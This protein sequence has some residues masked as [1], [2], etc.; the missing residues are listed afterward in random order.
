M[1]KWVLIALGLVAVVVV[2]VATRFFVNTP[3]QIE[4]AQ[5]KVV[6]EPLGITPAARALDASLDVAD[7][8]ADSLLWKRDLLERSDR[9]HV[10][11]PRLIEA[12]MRFRFSRR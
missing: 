6:A 5:N 11:L 7:M 12:I 9:G 10:D 2:A 4:R 8:H 3:G 1:R